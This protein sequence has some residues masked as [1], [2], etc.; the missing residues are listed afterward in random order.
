VL[1]WSDRVLVPSPLSR[2]VIWVLLDVGALCE[3]APPVLVCW[4][5][6]PPAFPGVVFVLDLTLP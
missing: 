2:A 5:L 4:A 1:C 3:V 6:T